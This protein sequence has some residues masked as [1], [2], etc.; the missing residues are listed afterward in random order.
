LVKE[1][2]T[3]TYTDFVNG[4][5]RTIQY[6]LDRCEKARRE[7]ILA[8]EEGIDS[9]KD[10]Y[11]KEGIRLVVDGVDAQTI[12]FILS[13]RAE[14]E[15]DEYRK[16]LMEIQLEGILGIQAGCRPPNL[17]MLLNSMVCIPDDPLT[18]LCAQYIDGYNLA[19]EDVDFPMETEKET[20][21]EEIRFI[22]RAV[23]LAEKARREG[24]LSLDKMLDK[25]AIAHR[26]ILEYGLCFVIDGESKEFIEK[27]LGNLIE[28]ENDPWKKNLLKAKKVAVLAIQSGDNPR[29]LVM[30]LLS[31][32]G[33]DVRAIIEKE[34]WGG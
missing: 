12:R 18:K 19:F 10:G 22:K 1:E 13:N 25:D 9:F 8:L 31:C 34:E 28:H 26:D 2:G 29:I 15:H 24:I 30:E 3:L 6:V 33:S 21:R 32:F 17:M 27:I 5:Y 16:K 4:Y 11:F 7:G 23:E 20:E 14:R